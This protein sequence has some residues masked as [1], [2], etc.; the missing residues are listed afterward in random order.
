M[1]IWVVGRIILVHLYMCLMAKRFGEALS[2]EEASKRIRN[3]VPKTADDDLDEYLTSLNYEELA[4]LDSKHSKCES[5][6]KTVRVKYKA[7][8]FY[9]RI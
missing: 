9:C 1:G 8:V 4:L 7:V 3:A 6:V 5:R 2:V